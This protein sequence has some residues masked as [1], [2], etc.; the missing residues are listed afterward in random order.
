M[1]DR[2]PDGPDGLR[3]LARAWLA[4]GRP[5]MVVEVL[6]TRGSVPREAGTRMLVAAEATAGTIGGGHLEFD[7]IAEARRA[8]VERAPHR[9]PRDIAL[10]PSLGQCCGGAVRLGLRRLD[11]AALADWPDEPP[12]FH[13]QL[14]GA[15]HVGQ[16]LVR[17]LAT[18]RCRVHW[19]DDRD[20][21]AEAALAWGPGPLPPH[22]TLQAGDDPLAEV[23]AAPPGCWFLVMTHSHALDLAL[24]QAVLARGDAGW[25]GLIGSATK[26]ARFERRL[27]ERGLGDAARTQMVCPIGLPGITGKAPPVV[28]MAVAAQLL[29]QAGA[30]IQASARRP[31]AATSSTRT[32]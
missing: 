7:A 19:V 28:A 20:T 3:T 4:A 24:V 8:L 2:L 1:T 17:L 9:P 26:R 14:H 11:A 25:L 10:G 6:A 30:V 22:I 23:A 5:A 13:L 27:A 29:Q 31:S 18:L 21:A 12:L 15:G 32:M 16:A